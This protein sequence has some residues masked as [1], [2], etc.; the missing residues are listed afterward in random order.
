MNPESTSLLLAERLGQSLL[1]ARLTLVTAESCTGGG[2]AWLI[3]S[4]PGSSRWFERGL[5]AYANTAKQELLGVSHDVLS[6]YGA[7]SEPTALAMAQGALANSHADISVAVT[8]IAGPEGGTESKPVGTV[9]FAW[10]RRDGD[11]RSA[12]TVFAGDRQQVREQAV[13]MAVQGLLDMVESA[14]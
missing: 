11:S 10:S 4:I 12:R 5:V 9:C 8:G 13:L 7:V 2:I 14:E 1:A 3:T 6:T